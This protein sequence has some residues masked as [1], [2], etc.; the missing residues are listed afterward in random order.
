[1]GVGRGERWME[2]EMRRWRDTKIDWW[3]EGRRK[4]GRRVGEIEV[5]K[6]VGGCRGEKER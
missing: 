3:R 2:A 6:R 4:W 1:M 5:M